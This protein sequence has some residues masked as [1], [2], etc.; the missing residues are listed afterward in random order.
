MTILTFGTH[1]GQKLSEIPLSYLL[2]LLK[3]YSGEYRKEI[4]EE[5][6]IRGYEKKEGVWQ[7]LKSSPQWQECAGLAFKKDCL[8]NIVIRPLKDKS[9]DLD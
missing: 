3:N 8:G 9:T 6:L 4:E 1:K 2:W 5:G 7:F